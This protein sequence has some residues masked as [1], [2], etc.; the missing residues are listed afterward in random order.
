MSHHLDSPLARE[1]PRLDISDVYLFRGRRGTVFVLNANPLS[2]AGGF[3]PEG[4]YEFRIDTDGDVVEDLTF[5]VRFGPMEP[6]GLQSLELRELRGI[7]A[8]DRDAD[9]RPVLS[10]ATQQPL[11]ADNGLRVWA[12]PAADP[13]YIDGGVVG[14]VVRAVT[15]GVRLDLDDVV[16]VEHANAFAGTNVSTIVLEVPDEVFGARH[17]AFWATTAL[18]TD[19]GGWRQI[20]RCAQPLVNTIFHPDDSDQASGYNTTHPRDDDEIYGERFAAMAAGAASA[21]GS[22][23]DPAEHGSRV[24]DLLLPD[25]LRYEIGTSACFGFTARNG[26]GLTECAPEVMFAIVLGAA[27]PLGLDATSAPG[28]LRD[29]LPYLALPIGEGSDAD[30]E[31][32][33]A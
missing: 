31:L 1:D 11:E 9:V 2:G 19:A 15:S 3:H 4:L 30:A 6:D 25:V 29:D 23:S 24:R 20:N 18:A 28:E 33:P 7:D 32:A 5:Q 21:L 8:Q 17:I 12:G 10:G 22:A 14:P 13:F 26:R 16:R 27:V